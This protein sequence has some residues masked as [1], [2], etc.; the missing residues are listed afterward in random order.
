MSDKVFIDLLGLSISADGQFAI[1][2]AVII[3]LS[4]VRW[5]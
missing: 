5:R 4:F 2:A 3:V 1:F